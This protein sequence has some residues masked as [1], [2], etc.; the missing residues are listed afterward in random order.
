MHE[1]GF[2]SLRTKTADC[3]SLVFLPLNF[4]I[5]DYVSPFPDFRRKPR[6]HRAHTNTLSGTSKWSSWLS[7][8]PGSQDGTIVTRWKDGGNAHH[9]NKYSRFTVKGSPGR[10]EYMGPIVV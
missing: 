9:Q 10:F 3:T 2:I 7:T 8:S 4:E 6:N 5:V 1:D